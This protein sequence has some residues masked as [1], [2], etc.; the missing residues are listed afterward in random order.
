MKHLQLSLLSFSLAALMTG[1]GT[2]SDQP[3]LTPEIVSIE[4]DGTDVNN[5]IHAIIIDEDL[6]QKQLSATVVYDDNTSADATEQLDWDSNDTALTVLNGLLTPAANGGA[7]LISASYRGKLFTTKDKNVTIVPLTDIN[8]T[9]QDINLTA[10]DTNSTLYHL[11]TNTTG[12]YTLQAYGTFKDNN[13]TTEPISS[14]I[15]WTS[16][17]TTVATVDTAGLL[18][19]KSTGFSDINASVYQDINST[20]ELNVTIP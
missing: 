20:L 8:I 2:E 13:F 4:I 9:S 12:S 11:D 19:I 15:T 3:P 14:H 7:A 1:C 18:T 17:N 6:L 5:S 16:S 10:D